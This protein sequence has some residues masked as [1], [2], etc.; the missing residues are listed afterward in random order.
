MLNENEHWPKKARNI[1][2]HYVCKPRQ[3]PLGYTLKG[4]GGD[5][6]LSL[7]SASRARPTLNRRRTTWP[8]HDFGACANYKILGRNQP[9]PSHGLRGVRTYLQN[10][11]CDLLPT[12]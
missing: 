4:A 8:A 6:E 5:W 7:R 3:V 12:Q 1:H 11:C 9:F 10:T 2:L